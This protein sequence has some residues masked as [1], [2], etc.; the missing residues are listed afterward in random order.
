M[1]IE[2]PH[3]PNLELVALSVTAGFAGLTADMVATALPKNADA[4][5]EEGFVVVS[6]IPA[7]Q[8]QID[9]PQDDGVVQFDLYATAGK[10]GGTLAPWAKCWRLVE[11]CRAGFDAEVFPYGKAVTLPDDYAPARVL[12]GYMLTEPERVPNDPSAFAHL[13]FDAAIHW[14]AVQ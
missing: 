10:K 1:S 6:A 5:A 12:S 8:A 9:L 14:T 2:A 3:R 13:T 4:W 7:G 11:L